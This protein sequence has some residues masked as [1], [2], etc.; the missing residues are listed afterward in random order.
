MLRRR[1]FLK[2]SA[3]VLAAA[4]VPAAAAMGEVLETTVEVDVSES[5]ASINMMHDQWTSIEAIDF[6]ADDGEIDITWRDHEGV[7]HV[8]TD[9]TY[10]TLET[11]L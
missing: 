2:G 3:G 1:S 9:R 6:R 4:S 10:I 7:E 11:N 5:L 8:T